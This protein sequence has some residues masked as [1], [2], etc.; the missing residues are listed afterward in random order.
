MEDEHVYNRHSKTLLLY[1]IV[2]PIKYRR[3]VITEAIGKS[4][5]GICLEISER[6]DLKFLEIGY[7]SDHVH[8]LIQS[9]P[10]YSV[11]DMVMKLKSISA[12]QLFLF[13]PE[14]KKQLW[15]GSLWTSGYYANTVGL[16]GSRD[17]IQK[18]VSSQGKD[19]EYRK[20]H[21][22]GQLSLFD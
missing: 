4:L 7:E 5:R 3:K 20:I 19:K 18:Y 13:H 12:K 1:H 17:V 6:Y 21:D 14:I 8:F 2:L 22:D 10:N 11:S 9:V 15:G 16:Y